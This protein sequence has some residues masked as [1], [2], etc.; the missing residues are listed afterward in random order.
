MGR[1]IHLAARLVGIARNLE[2]WELGRM[3]IGGQQWEKEEW[4]YSVIF[5]FTSRGRK[6]LNTS[7]SNQ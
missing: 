5:F 2:E 4:V 6:R 3:G 1:R 7:K